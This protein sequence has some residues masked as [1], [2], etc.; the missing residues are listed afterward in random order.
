MLARTDLLDCRSHATTWTLLR[1]TR[2]PAIRIDTGY[3]TNPGDRS[4]LANAH[5]IDTLAEG[6]AQGVVRYFS[7]GEPDADVESAPTA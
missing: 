2:M 4:R 3:L 1:L 7:P 5:F 6:I